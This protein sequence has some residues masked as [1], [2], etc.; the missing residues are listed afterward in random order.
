MNAAHNLLH[1][2]SI[3]LDKLRRHV[4]I[5]SIGEQPIDL[6]DAISVGVLKDTL[7][8]GAEA[9]SVADD[10]L[11]RVM[12]QSVLL[13]FG[14]I[15]N[16][17]LHFFVILLG[18]FFLVILFGFATFGILQSLTNHG[19]NNRLLLFSQSIKYIGNGLFAVGFLSL[20]FCHGFLFVPFL[21]GFCVIRMAHGSAV[22]FIRVRKS[23]V[24]TGID[25]RL[26]VRFLTMLD[27]RINKSTRIRAS[28]NQAYFA[29]SP[30][31]NI[32]TLLP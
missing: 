24:L 18:I 14:L 7:L 13:S 23:N 15:K 31:N 25:D 10:S 4:L 11:H 29:N 20:V 2:S 17:M 21:F 5:T 22:I 12:A 30:M 32:R 16:V 28:Q 27:N 26:F 3:A 19:V 8:H 9:L 1:P 6:L